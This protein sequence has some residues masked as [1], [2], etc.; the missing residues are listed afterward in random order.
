MLAENQCCG[1]MSISELAARAGRESDG[2]PLRRK[3]ATRA[4]K[5]ASHCAGGRGESGRSSGHDDGT[6]GPVVTTVATVL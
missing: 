2:V 5:G 1:S 4:P 6:V 3:M